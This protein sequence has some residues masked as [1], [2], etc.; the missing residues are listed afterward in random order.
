MLKTLLTF[1]L[2]FSILLSTFPVFAQ[3]QRELVQE[4]GD[5]KPQKRT[6]LV[7]GNANYTVARKLANPSNDA[8]DMTNSLKSLGFEV[9]SG[10]NLNL[11]QMNDKVREFGDKL[12]ANGGVGL[13]YYAGHGIQ[14]SGRN[15]LIPVD[16]EIPREDEV[17]FNALNMDLILRKMATAN[18]GLNIVILDACRNNPFAR[19]WSRSTDEGG[20]A[21]ISAPTGT[22]IAYATAPDRTASDGDG[23]NGLYTAELLKVMRQ[24]NMKIEDAFKQVTISVDRTS[25]GKQ[26]PWT[27]SSLRGEFYFNADG[28]VA[29]TTI[30]QPVTNPTT[31]LIKNDDPLAEFEEWNKVKTSANAADY[32]SYLQ[33][34]PNGS[35]AKQARDKMNEIGDPEWNNVKTSKDATVFRDYLNKNPNSP[36]ADE[37]RAKMR[38]LA[39]SMIAWEQIKDSKKYEDFE[40]YIKKYPNSAQIDEAKKAIEPL[41][42][43][44][45]MKNSTGIEFVY[46]PA[47]EFMMGSP[48]TEKGRNKDEGP[49]R[50][51]IISKAFWMSKFPI[52][53]RQFQDLTNKLS[54]D[55]LKWL[56]KYPE[57]WSGYLSSTSLKTPMIYINTLQEKDSEFFYSLPTEAEWEYA[58][59]GNTTTAYFWGNDKDQE[60]KINPFGLHG[61]LLV[62]EW[63]QDIYSENYEGLPTDGSAN[64]TI[65]DKDKNVTR[66][67]ICGYGFTTKCDNRVANR[68][69]V[70]R[71]SAGFRVVARPRQ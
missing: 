70:G 28:K 7:I 63:V 16:A 64:L 10:T 30:N 54:E 44:R 43:G 59:R 5:T 38:M 53:N 49:Q 9:V 34:Y 19:S 42:A 27:S 48:E 65:G 17:D 36:F 24:P 62:R 1:C 52:T 23:R 35:F 3:N 25:G 18:N 26:V 67:Y 4:N 6:A 46:I 58:A 47:G 11:K 40:E 33:K 21:Q 13:F 41:M 66:G 39:E 61:M 69:T 37:A 57:N 51:V 15:Y 68:R 60:Q 22:F 12:K 71:Y 2:K 50:K 55:Y 29:K 14:V 32:Q 20:L 31:N 56:V 45:T 8:T